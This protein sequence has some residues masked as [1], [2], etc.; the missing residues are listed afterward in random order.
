MMHKCTYPW[1]RIVSKRSD[2]LKDNISTFFTLQKSNNANL[3]SLKVRGCQI[4]MQG[5]QLWAKHLHF[6]KL[7]VATSRIAILDL[8]LHVLQVAISNSNNWGRSLT[9]PSIQT[10]FLYFFAQ[11]CKISFSCFCHLP[12]LLT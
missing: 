10:N 7:D 6:F 11:D 3:L 1:W 12:T 9:P 4:G 5:P 2:N 8:K